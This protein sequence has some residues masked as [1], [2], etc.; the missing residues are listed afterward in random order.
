MKEDTE[1][2]RREA[3]AYLDG[4]REKAPQVQP[5]DV[6]LF[7][8]ALDYKKLP[9]PL[10]LIMKERKAPEG[11]FRNWEAI[12]AWAAEVRPALLGV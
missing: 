11:D 6:C 8:G 2:H 1:E 9:L 4:V 5:V 3:A 12:R 7:A 10:K